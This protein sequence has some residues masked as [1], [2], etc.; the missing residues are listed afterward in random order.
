MRACKCFALTCAVLALP[1]AA[2]V[3]AADWPVS[4]GD[5]L[6]T[7]T[8][9]VKLP[10]QL[11][12]RWVFKCKDSVE[13]AP[14]IDNGVAYVASMDKHLYAID[15]TSGKEKWR[16]SLGHMKAPPAVRG[17]R[18]YV[19][20]IEN[21][22]YAVDAATGKVVWTFET[23]GEI[24]AGANFYKDTIIF[25]C[26]DS[27]LYC[28]TADGKKAWDLK[29]DGPIN[30]ASAVV[31]DRTFATGCSDGALHVVDATNGKDL[32]TIDLGGQTVG[33]AAVS[34]DLVVLGMMTNQV[35]AADW[36]TLKKAW[37]FEPKRRQQ[38][39]YASAAVTEKL[40]VAGSRDKKVYALDRATGKEVWNFVTE[41]SVDAAPVVVGNR[42][43]VGCLSDMGEFY[44][45]DLNTGKRVQEISL[46][47]AVT[48]SVGVGPDCIVVGTEKG[49]VHCL[50][51]KAK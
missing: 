12:E 48:G 4:R 16:A 41:G 43:Y 47:G 15:L 45:L 42:V 26:H 2:L 35:V 14:A 33:T 49:A 36:K 13:A 51:T 29:I 25:G 40:V 28:L 34:G 18:V 11:A 23:G 24:D 46:E 8:S 6:M 39:F 10:D 38:P 22:F 17:G 50:G 7:G 9:Q 32:G 20:T 30:A 44:V 5:A 21:Q 37:E 27:S 1:L 19:G 3:P 31:G